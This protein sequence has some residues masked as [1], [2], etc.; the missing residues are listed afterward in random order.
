V[1]DDTQLNINLGATYSLAKQW[2]LTPRISHTKNSSNIELNE[3]KR[4]MASLALRRDF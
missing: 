1:R 4:T 3:Y 2:S